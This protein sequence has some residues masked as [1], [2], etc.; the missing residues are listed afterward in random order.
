MLQRIPAHLFDSLGLL[1]FRALISMSHFK[2]IVKFNFTYL[3]RH[4]KTYSSRISLSSRHNIRNI[5]HLYQVD[6]LNSYPSIECPVW[7]AFLWQIS[8][9]TTRHSKGPERNLN[10]GAV[11]DYLKPIANLACKTTQ[12]YI[13]AVRKKSVLFIV[14]LGSPGTQRKTQRFIDNWKG[15]HT[16]HREKEWWIERREGFLKHTGKTHLGPFGSNKNLLSHCPDHTATTTT[17]I[18]L[19]YQLKQLLFTQRSLSTQRISVTWYQ[20]KQ[21]SAYTYNVAH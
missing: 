5:I 9:L 16:E 6:T 3:S 14:S 12:W 15:R 21:T 7:Y 8:F 2:P 20:L 1:F 19:C 17:T 18:T 13:H 10:S 4:F 11:L